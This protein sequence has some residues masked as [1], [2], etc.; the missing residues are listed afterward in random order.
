MFYAKKI[1]LFLLIVF[2][3]AAAIY[4]ISATAQIS[5][6][7]SYSY[8]GIKPFD[9]GVF[10]PGVWTLGNASPSTVTCKGK[11]GLFSRSFAVK[12]AVSMAVSYGMNA[13]FPGIGLFFNTGFDTLPQIGLNIGN[14]SG[15][16]SKFGFGKKL[17][18]IGHPHII[19]MVGTSLTP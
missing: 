19:Q 6:S 15:L 5:S 8:S 13:L 2:F 9:Y 3:S 17:D 4:P 14:I 10:A 16:I 7:Y 18:T 11:S 1:I 12:M